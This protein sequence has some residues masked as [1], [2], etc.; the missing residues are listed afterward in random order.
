MLRTISTNACS[1]ATEALAKSPIFVLR[2][3]QVDEA[4]GMLTLSGSVDTFYHKQ[5]AQEIVRTAAEDCELVNSVSVEYTTP[6]LAR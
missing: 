1:R 5:L 3:L 4:G 2:E 6:R